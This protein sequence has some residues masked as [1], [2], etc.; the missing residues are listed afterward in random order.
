MVLKRSFLKV[1]M[2]CI[3]RLCVN[4]KVLLKMSQTLK[5]KLP[6]GKYKVEWYTGWCTEWGKRSCKGSVDQVRTSEQ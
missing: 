6:A 4:A 5:K 2:R 3:A 1:P